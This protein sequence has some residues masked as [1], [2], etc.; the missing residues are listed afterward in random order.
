MFDLKNQVCLITGSYGYLAINF[1][2]DILKFNPI[3]ILTGRNLKK[4]KCQY[5]ELYK[6]YNNIYMFQLDIT[7]DNKIKELYK[8]IEEKFN[9]LDIIINNAN[10]NNKIKPLERKNM[11]DV[12][13]CL[14]INVVSTFNLIKIFIPL[15]IK[16]TSLFDKSTSVINFSTIYSNNAPKK[17]IY[18][19]LDM[20]NPIEYG[21]SK[22]SI[23]QMT[24][25]FAAYYG[26]KNIRFNLISPGCFPNLDNVKNEVF[27]NNLKKKSP[28]NRI[29]KPSELSGLIV[30]LA[31]ESSSFITGQNIYVDGGANCWM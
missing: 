6:N 17:N 27:L 11:K 5:D 20:V 30:F 8:F 31:S 4:L 16:T 9:R 28:M 23:N 26:D 14:N 10:Y 29:G 19:S 24:K 22:S 2:K 12:M 13:D 7:N 25:Y 3:I 1:I 18:P 15:L 21:L